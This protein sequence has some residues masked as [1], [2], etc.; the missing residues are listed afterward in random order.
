MAPLDLDVEAAEVFVFVE[1][2]AVAGLLLLT[3]FFFL[4]ELFFGFL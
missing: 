3:T 1:V 4:P 2:A